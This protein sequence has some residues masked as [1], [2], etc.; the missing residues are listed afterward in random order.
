MKPS[1]R[2]MTKD[3]EDSKADGK[4]RV[5]GGGN[6]DGPEPPFNF[7]D[8]PDSEEVGT[9]LLDTTG[10]PRTAVPMPGWLDTPV[11]TLAAAA[12]FAA[13]A[14]DVNHPSSFHLLQ[15]IDMAVHNW[16]NLHTTPEFRKY[17]A[18]LAISDVWPIALVCGW[19][20]V[21]VTLWSRNIKAGL[22]SLGVGLPL[23]LFGGGGILH[24]DPWL[25]DT[26][27]QIAERGRPSTVLHFTYSFPS[28]HTTASTFMA[29]YLAFAL[30]PPL[31]D[32]LPSKVE[33]SNHVGHEEHTEKKRDLSSKLLAMWGGA[34]LMTASGR[35]L[36]DVH[37]FS[38][39]L[40][41]ALLGLSLVSLG[42]VV[43]KPIKAH[44]KDE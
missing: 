8:L 10:L 24:G 31:I 36:A 27:K 28:G 5:G 41:G 40:G 9:A 1:A 26:I 32:S 12:A 19:I 6:G 11:F 15:P 38:D 23:Y 13:V 18:D 37:W 43:V 29:G 30:L 3:S 25:V 14:F 44:Q 21:S 2:L 7:P 35:M 16:V 20:Y 22:R 42:T 4:P 17:A 33:D 39:T 34:V